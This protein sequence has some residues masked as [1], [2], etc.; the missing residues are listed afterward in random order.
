MISSAF[1]LEKGPTE[2]CKFRIRMLEHYIGR[3]KALQQ[4]EKALHDSMCAEIRPVMKSKRLLLFQEMMRDA[5]VADESLFVDMCQGFKLVGDLDPSGQFPH[6]FKPASL[7]VEQLKQTAKWAQEAVVASCRK[8]ADDAEIA[9]AVWE[10]TLEQALPEKQWVRGPFTAEEISKRQ[11]SHWIPSRRF[12][13]RQGGKIRSVDEF[14]QYL[15]NATVTA[16]EKIDLQALT[17]FALLL[18]SSLGLLLQMLVE[19]GVYLTLQT[20]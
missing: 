9:T 18:V 12:G 14:S 11:G 1:I 19:S 16:H 13:V 2:V 15:V 5:R 8:V 20:L 3:A 6:Q 7:D 10:E 4:D 17:A